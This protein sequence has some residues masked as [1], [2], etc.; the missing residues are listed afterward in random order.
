VVLAHAELAMDLT[1]DQADKLT[2]VFSG[3]RC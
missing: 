2:K 3:M 1:G